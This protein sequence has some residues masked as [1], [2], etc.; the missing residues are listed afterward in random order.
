MKIRI[1][2]LTILIFALISCSNKGAKQE[3]STSIDTVETFPIETIKRVCFERK[4]H[5]N[6]DSLNLS[7]LQI[8]DSS[9]FKKWFDKRVIDNIE[10]TNIAFDQNSR[11]YFFDFKDL[12]KLF[13]FSIIYNDEIGYNH[14]YHFTFDKEK[15]E[16]NQID[17]I[18][19]TGGDGGDN[20]I[21]ILNFNQNG[22]KFRLTSISTYDEDF[23]KG[24]IRQYDSTITDI[25]FNYRKTKFKKINSMSR[26]DT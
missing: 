7:K 17:L 25:E 16:I 8:I 23:D 9:F 18:A 21:D 6:L 15:N 13:L 5:Y 26:L 14:L 20:N 3:N 10:N 24:Y 19:Q 11:Y 12:D 1:H 4:T 2:I 22:D